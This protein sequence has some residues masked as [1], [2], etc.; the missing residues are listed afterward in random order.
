MSSAISF[1][2]KALSPDD[3]T[4]VDDGI[5]V[6]EQPARKRKRASCVTLASDRPVRIEA[7]RLEIE[8]ERLSV[9]KKRL[10]IEKKRLE[11]EQ[12]RLKLNN[13]TIR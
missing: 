2:I 12:E 9:E 7:H 8:K 1:N 11:V 3:D 4:S 6:R 5:E 10:Q 13:V